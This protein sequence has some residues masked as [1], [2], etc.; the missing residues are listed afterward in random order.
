MESNNLKHETMAV[1]GM[2]CASCGSIITKKL[3]KLPG[4]ES[5][6]VNFATEKATVAYNPEAV[7]VDQMNKEI[8][9]LGYTLRSSDTHMN[10]D[11]SGVQ[12]NMQ[13]MEHT[14]PGMDHSEHLGLTQTDGEK[15]RELEL[16]KTK[17]EFSL[18]L[19][20]L[21]FILMMWD[22]AARTIPQ[23][24]NLPIPMQLFA[25]L[26][27]I[28]ASIVLFWVGKPYLV[29]VVRFIQYRVANMDSLV[30]I[31]TI[32]AYVYSSIIFLFPQIRELLNLPEYTYF[33]VTIVVVGF[34]TLG[35]FLEARSKLQTGEAI[36]KLLNLAAKTAVVKR[37]GKEIEIPIS[38]VQVGDEIIVK[39]GAK[40]PVDGV[41]LSGSTSVDES[42]ITGES[43]PMDKHIGDIVVGAT[44]NKQGSITI[45]ATKVGKETMLS[46]IITLVEQ[47]QGSRAA[48]Q[49]MADKISAVFIPAVLIIAIIALIA[50]LTIGSYFLG[51]NVAISYALLAFVGILVIACPCALGL[52]TPTAIIVGV[53]KGA[54][55]GILI[56][57]ADSLE[58][59]HT[60]T[61]LAF[62]KTGTI[63]TGKPSVT[64]IVSLDPAYDEHH[65]LTIAA[66]IEHHSQHPL[67]LAITETAKQKQIDT[68]SVSDFSEKEGEG[69]Q[70]N[71]DGKQYLVRKPK[72]K[73]HTNPQ[74]SELQEQGKTVVVIEKENNVIGIIAISDTIK[75][76]AKQAIARLKK[77]GIELVLITGDNK[78]AAEFIARQVGIEIVRSEVLPADKSRIVKELQE[79]GKRVGM[80]G[81]GI[82]DAPALTTAHVGI[83][84]STGTD[85]AIESADLTLLGADL[86]KIPQAIQLSHATIRTI[87][88]NLFWAFIY[89]VI[90]I[91]LAAG[92]FYPLFG[93]FLNPIFAGFAMAMSSVSVVSNSL[94]LKK[95]RIS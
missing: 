63:T 87:K 41:I 49:N 45:K 7:S 18:P 75:D 38:E 84:M 89:N 40:V 48:I 12:H 1:T 79:K 74:I 94:L 95:A 44:M 83:A 21:V 47:A 9:K 16:L 2:H 4:V 25:T 13:D 73:D 56:K 52:A 51:I 28:L 22:I 82:N 20:F 67:A 58:K 69:V 59:L 6:E 90:G 57:N 66:S 91:P 11:R 81:D 5:C 61:T 34:I 93:I 43:L 32:T 55:H 88:M 42:M 80:V 14:M 10:H 31:G 19:T 37:D 64:D 26:S 68:N 92:L 15:K 30:G 27:F 70:G 85:V 33:D 46:Q 72:D 35:K 60:I 53:G 23:V 8:E 86:S 3:K 36:K 17:V 77:M 78:R 65:V 76:N 50:W 24:P 54:E 29:A 71:I 62:D 39:P